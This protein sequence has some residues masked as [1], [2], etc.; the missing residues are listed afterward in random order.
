MP[1]RKQQPPTVLGSKMGPFGSHQASLLVHALLTAAIVTADGVIGSPA[2]EFPFAASTLTQ[3]GLSDGRVRFQ[4]GI[5]KAL[6]YAETTGT[7]NYG[8]EVT[9]GHR[10]SPVTCPPGPE[11]RNYQLDLTCPGCG[12]F[13]RDRS[14]ALPMNAAG[15]MDVIGKVKS[16]VS[17]YGGEVKLGICCHDFEIFCIKTCSAGK[18]TFQQDWTD[19]SIRYN[20]SWSPTLL[21]V[22][23]AP[24]NPIL[25]WV[26]SIEQVLSGCW[27]THKSHM[28]D[29]INWCD[30]FRQEITQGVT[31]DFQARL[32]TWLD[33]NINDPLV[34]KKQVGY[35]TLTINYHPYNM[36]FFA[37]RTNILYF[38]NLSVANYNGPEGTGTRVTSVWTPQRELLCTPGT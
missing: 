15:G 20:V 34:I 37:N 35:S 18:M 17:C 22:V 23:P 8:G 31:A 5:Q 26:F 19:I 21:K 9:C 4:D 24:G 6:T 29:F 32:G 30:G 16:S 10:V 13:W 33:A 38:A 12:I 7:Y 2:N 11:N 28:S 36:S 14:G 25:D 3:S 1:D 27:L